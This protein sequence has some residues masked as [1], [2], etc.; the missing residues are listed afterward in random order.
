[1][2]ALIAAPGQYVRPRMRDIRQ[3]YELYARSSAT[4]RRRVV[5]LTLADDFTLKE[6]CAGII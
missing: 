4:V 1:M 6:I 3:I 2:L 5:L